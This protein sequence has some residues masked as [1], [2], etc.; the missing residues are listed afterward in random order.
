M[1][2]ATPP[3]V[4]L[5]KR[6]PFN[7]ETK[8]LIDSLGGGVESITPRSSRTARNSNPVSPLPSPASSRFR[9][10]SRRRLRKEAEDRPSP[11][12]ACSEPL[13]S[14]SSSSVVEN[15]LAA[16]H[17]PSNPPTC[18]S[19]PSLLTPKSASQSTLAQS[20]ISHPKRKRNAAKSSSSRRPG[21]DSSLS[22]LSDSEL[23][24]R[25][26]K[27]ASYTHLRPM[28]NSSG[29][30]L[31]PPVPT[32]PHSTPPTTVTLPLPK[33]Q[34]SLDQPALKPQRLILKPP[35]PQ[36]SCSGSSLSTTVPLLAPLPIP[37]LSIPPKSDSIKTSSLKGKGKA[38]QVPLLKGPKRSGK[39]STLR[40]R[41]TSHTPRSRRL[42]DLQKQE[43]E[44]KRTKLLA[45]LD[46]EEAMIRSSSHP[47]LVELQANIDRGRLLK[48]RQAQLRH[49]A[50]KAYLARQHEEQEERIWSTWTDE[51]VKLRSELLLKCQLQL[52][53]APFDFVMSNDTSNLQAMFHLTPLPIPAPFVRDVSHTISADSVVAGL[54]RQR[55]K[56]HATWILPSAAIES[57]LALLRG[58][59]DLGH[60]DGQIH[61]KMQADPAASSNST[62]AATSF[63]QL[64]SRV[65]NS[66]DPLPTPSS[67]QVQLQFALAVDHA[68]APITNVSSSLPFPTSLTN[69]PEARP[70]THP[71][72]SS[73]VKS[74][75]S[76]NRAKGTQSTEPSTDGPRRRSS[77][78]HA[79]QLSNPP[80]SSTSIEPQPEKANHLRASRPVS[81]SQDDIRGVIH[82]WAFPEAARHSPATASQSP[83]PSS[84]RTRALE[85]HLD[86]P[87]T[88]KRSGPTSHP[89]LSERGPHDP[90]RTPSH[91]HVPSGLAYKTHS[92]VN[93]P[94]SSTHRHPPARAMTRWVFDDAKVPNRLS[95]GP[96]DPA[97]AY[98]PSYLY[99]TRH[100]EHTPNESSRPYPSFEQ[101][102]AQHFDSIDVNGC[103]LKRRRPGD[104]VSY[105]MGV[106]QQSMG[107]QVRTLAEQGK[108]V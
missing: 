28:P 88:P 86:H 25:P 105:S 35:L 45:S 22:D 97:L 90:A 11:G 32:R 96:T 5:P 78:Q 7:R 48:L 68:A 41:S 92:P 14:A 95:S 8:S 42:T 20:P 24:N 55:V 98:A 63:T 102:Q 36:P 107:P 3:A 73:S 23:G 60:T 81:S 37:T 51:K 76:R 66:P 29:L 83:S 89:E 80:S 9:I 56:N 18:A 26:K 61:A 30:A 27:K 82:S 46:E 12:S 54:E 53:R 17:Q 84:S 103:G 99:P 19:T 58:A 69:V 67:S 50:L 64:E 21:S 91:T 6:P 2:T 108:L 94:S 71:S 15:P 4:P 72:K 106:E 104:M 16:S 43:I 62:R 10:P 101:Y 70:K 75:R 74:V 57:D 93:Y 87:S 31:P 65:K 79:K 1:A 85:P 33:I 34:L 77:R 52:A 38:L 13:I 100:T 59:S 40:S 39:S 47:L 49:E 44:Q